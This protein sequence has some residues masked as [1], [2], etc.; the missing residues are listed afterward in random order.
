MMGIKLKS[1]RRGNWIGIAI[2]YPS[3]AMETVAMILMPPDNDWRATI[4]FYDEL[5]RLYKKRLSKCL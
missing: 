4:E 3:G 5:I 1:Q 2:I